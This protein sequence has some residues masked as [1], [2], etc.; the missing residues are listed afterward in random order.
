M[1]KLLTNSEMSTWREC[2]RKWYLGTFRG[3]TPRKR[4][5]FN[6]PISIGNRVHDA[7]AA[8]YD[9]DI[10]ADPVQHVKDSIAEDVAKAPDEE[11]DIRKEGDLAVIM[12]E[13]YVQWLEEEGADSEYTVVH[14]SEEAV[15]V[16]L[17]DGV[18]L[19]TKLD[20]RVEDHRGDYWG[21]DH[22]TGTHGVEPKLLQLNTQ[23]LT[24]H[25][26]EFLKRTE[27]GDQA[28]TAKGTVFNFLRKVKRTA[29]AKP[30]FY[31]REEVRHN[32]EELRNHWKH[33]AAVAHEILD[34]EARLR[35][36]ED[37]HVV[38]YPSP[39]KD[40]TWKC[41]FFKVCGLHDDGSNVE[42]AIADLYETHDPLERYAVR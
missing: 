5:G 18:D 40:C 20:V 22:K 29:R 24:Q 16:P 42:A 8:Y 1:T 19:L 25:L 27:Q 12:I 39:G 28:Q 4:V 26:I 30:P 15:T 17:I 32:D 7:L 13:G 31:W 3:L 2:K 23:A 37:H 14:G 11:A 21:L 33:A 6:S 41:P 10:R 34:A 36:G 35:A 38:A 9:P